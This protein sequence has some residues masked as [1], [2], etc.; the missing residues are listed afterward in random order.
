VA[1]GYTAP[2]IVKDERYSRVWICGPWGVCCIATV[3]IPAFYDESINVAYG[4][5]WR[6]GIILS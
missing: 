4:E 1:V 6:A 3:W 2:E 5:G